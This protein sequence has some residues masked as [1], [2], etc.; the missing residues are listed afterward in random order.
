MKLLNFLLLGFAAESQQ[1]VLKLGQDQK[2]DVQHWGWNINQA[3]CI[4]CVEYQKV[5]F[6]NYNG[7]LVIIEEAVTV[8]NDQGPCQYFDYLNTFH[9]GWAP[10][11]AVQA[12]RNVWG[13][14]K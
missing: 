4:M 7:S 12:A 8:C 5:Q 2:R 11:D 14:G 13:W 6:G 1:A 9:Y 3:H 10:P